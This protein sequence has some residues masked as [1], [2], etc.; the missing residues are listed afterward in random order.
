MALAVTPIIP[1][2]LPDHSPITVDR[3]AF[4]RRNPG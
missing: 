2:S 1:R 3:V 4:D